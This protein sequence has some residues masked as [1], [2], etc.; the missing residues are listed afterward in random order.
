MIKNI[1]TVILR[2]FSLL[3]WGF[4]LFLLL[5]VASSAYVYFREL[6]IQGVGIPPELFSTIL[7]LSLVGSFINIPLKTLEIN[8]PLVYLEQVNKFGVDWVIPQ[9]QMGKMKTL[10]T[11]N[12]GGGLVPIFISLYL[13]LF[14]IPRNSPDLLATYIKTLV[15]LVVVAISTYNSSEIVKGM[16]IATPAF[17][18]PTMTA[19]ITFLI[20]WVS[21]VTCPTQ[22]AYVGG[23][24]GALIGADILNLSRLSE[25]QAPSVSI[26]GAGTFDGVYLTGLVS[27][28]LVLLLR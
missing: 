6:L 13:L 11:I 22:I 10:L 2:P 14:S 24:L 1:R 21:P 12:V 19:F 5:T 26:G 9:V 17:G 18:P 7:F 8:N 4:L 27:V 28:L 23:T 25:L 20:N 3:Y 15:I 16:G